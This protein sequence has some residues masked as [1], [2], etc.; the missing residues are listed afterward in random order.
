MAISAHEAHS[1]DPKQ[2][3]N[4]EEARAAGIAVKTLL[5][6]RFHKIFYDCYVSSDVPIT[7][8]CEPMRL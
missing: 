6:S 4:R 3:F 7:R 1:F 5:S 2:P 8:G